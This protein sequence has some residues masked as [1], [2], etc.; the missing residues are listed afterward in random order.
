MSGPAPIR[1]R[2]AEIA[3]VSATLRRFALT[4]EDGALFPPAGAGA[5]VVLLLQG[6]DR[7]WRNAY[8]LV[9][10]PGERRRYEIVVRHTADSRGGSA[11]LHTEVRVGDVLALTPPVNT[12][13]IPKLAHRHLLI[14]GGV[15][16]TPF[17]SWLP[18]LRGRGIPFELH[19]FCRPED[20]AGIAGLL[21]SGR[22]EAIAVHTGL[23]AP[24]LSRE[25]AGRPLGT[26]LSLCGP[27]PFMVSVL[28]QARALGWPEAKLHIESFGAPAHGAAFRVTLARS[29]RELAV[30][31]DRGLLDVLE[32]AGLDPPYL[33][34]GGACG[35]CR[36]GVLDGVPEHRD[37][38]LTEG[39]R[40][41]GD[42]I[43]AC[44]SRA[45]TPSLVLDF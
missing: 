10:P 21:G 43:L 14:A 5:H 40:A 42:C 3:E 38:V 32:D 16:L 20:A 33:C 8:S 41:R 9:T 18:A 29:G 25:L 4:P 37:H 1:A 7:V 23:G 30:P 6:R 28:A 13:P 27:A 19:Q 26:H 15:G 24:D 35:Q 2:V 45:R 11:F 12:F 22:G 44:V 17:L 39:E 31:E 34:R 36:I